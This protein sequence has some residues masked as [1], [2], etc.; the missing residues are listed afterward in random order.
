MSWKACGYV[1]ELRDGLTIT[2]KFVLLVLAE[3]HRTDEKLAWP[4]VDTLA[5]DCLMTERGT[6]Q[7]LQRLQDK[8]FILRTIGGGRGHM[9][10][11]QIAGV[12]YKNPEPQ[13][14]N[15]Q[16]PFLDSVNETRHS[17]AVKGERNPAQ[18]CSAIRKEPVLEPVLESNGGTAPPDSQDFHPHQYAAK[19]ID[20]LQL[21]GYPIV[22]NRQNI[23]AISGRH[24][25]LV[26]GGI[27]ASGAYQK[28][29]SKA[30][31]D[32]EA[33][34][35]INSFYFLD[36]QRGTDGNGKQQTSASAQRTLNNRR[37]L[38]EAVRRHVGQTARPDGTER[39]NRTHD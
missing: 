19:I 14:L 8:G 22:N 28:I 18:P 3:Y 13:T 7:I 37:N 29:L 6:R 9:N 12:D 11:Y 4:S 25:A 2:E 15:V 32:S 1:K 21:A 23:E 38:V 35:L 5:S 17:H 31:D 34:V 20:D 16:T 27:S 24:A 33:G 36:G 30:L 10:G 26:R 39:E